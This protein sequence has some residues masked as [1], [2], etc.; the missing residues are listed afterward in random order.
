MSDDMGTTLAPSVLC[1]KGNFT[2]MINFTTDSNETR[3]FALS[4]ASREISYISIAICSLA[5][6]LNA[7]EIIILIK[8]LKKLSIFEI[9]LL[10]LAVADGMVSLAVIIFQSIRIS[11]SGNKIILTV[12]NFV[13]HFSLI[14]SSMTLILIAVDRLSAIKF[15]LKHKF[16]LTKKKVFILIIVVWITDIAFSCVEP[17][18]E[19]ADS[20]NQFRYSPTFRLIDAYMIVSMSSIFVVAYS[21]IIYSITVRWKCAQFN[22][23]GVKNSASKV[24]KNVNIVVIA[25]CILVVISYLACML[26]IAIST[27]IDATYE[28][29]GYQLLLVYSNSALDPLVYFFKKHFGTNLQKR[30]ALKRSRGKRSLQD[31]NSN[32]ET[33]KL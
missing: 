13:I 14:S 20:S 11:D 29:H 18:L 5:L 31:L 23:D 25:T 3:N 7:A 4:N 26:P 17:L 19:Y 27:F 33:M 6:L 1:C 21:L 28:P 9:W 8:T 12:A 32:T 15:P 2:Q 10:N 30:E 16:W 22:G 24:G